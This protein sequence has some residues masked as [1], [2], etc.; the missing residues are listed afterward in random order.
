VISTALYQYHQ[1][2]GSYPPAYVAG[3]DRRPMHSWRVLVLG[4][5]GYP[6]RHLY[7]AYDFREPWDGPHNSTLLYRMPPFY[8]CPNDPADTAAATSYALITGP[9]TAFPGAGT[10]TLDGLL[11]GRA[12]SMMVVE[13]GGASVPWMAPRDLELGPTAPR[14]RAP[15]QLAP[16]SGDRSGLAVLSFNGNRFRIGQTVGSPVL[17]DLLTARGPRNPTLDTLL[18]KGAATGYGFA[19]SRPLAKGR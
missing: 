8:G 4:V 2:Y 17:N 7:E 18:S 1:V 19:G 6:Y 9:G 16:S 13:I 10:T 3:A 5:M 14:D 12:G 15:G 11:G